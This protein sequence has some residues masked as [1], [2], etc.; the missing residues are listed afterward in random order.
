[1]AIKLS[2]VE[3]ILN[4][5]AFSYVQELYFSTFGPAAGYYEVRYRRRWSILSPQHKSLNSF[6]F[7]FFS[8][9]VLVTTEITI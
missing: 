6:K 3:F 5:L 9:W 1:M 8:R 7:L 4:R 2:R